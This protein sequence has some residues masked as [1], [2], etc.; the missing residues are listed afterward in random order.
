MELADVRDSKSRGSN[1]VR[2]RPPPPAPEKSINLDTRL[3]LFSVKSV[4][5]RDK[6]ALQM[7]SLRDEILLR[8]VK[9]AF[10][11]MDLFHFTESVSF[12]FHICPKANISLTNK[13]EIDAK[14][15]RSTALL[16]SN[17]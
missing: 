11:R 15:P 13:I 9:Y 5:R 7:K 12:L 17:R 8:N 6:S 4:L 1:T 3:M 10:R 16:S 2:V 14:V